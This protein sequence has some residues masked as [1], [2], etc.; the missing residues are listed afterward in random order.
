MSGIIFFETSMEGGKRDGK[1][2]YEMDVYSNPTMTLSLC[3]TQSYWRVLSYGLQGLCSQALE[4]L[5]AFT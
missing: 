4:L 3:A 2:L 1:E 5:I